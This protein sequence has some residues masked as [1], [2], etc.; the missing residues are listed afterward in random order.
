MNHH[1]IR[2]AQV[3]DLPRLFDVWHA[4]VIATHDFLGPADIDF[5]SPFV[6][7]E[8]ARATS[9]QSLHVLRCT[10]DNAYAFMCVEAHKI[11]MLFVRPDQRS[12]GAGSTLM[13]YATDKLGATTV[14]VNEHN[15]QGHD[16]YRHR[17]FIEESRSE[18]DPF[19]KPFPILHLKLA[20]NGEKITKNHSNS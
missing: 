13:A 2:P 16:F 7:I 6:R 5:L 4:A 10:D 15:T 9:V 11:E 20:K 8:L 19:G 17:G 12:N 18:L 14:D 1:T 3:S